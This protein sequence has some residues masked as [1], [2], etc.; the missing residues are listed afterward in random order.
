MAMDS[1]A[2]TLITIQINLAGGTLARHVHEHPS[3]RQ[4]LN[5]LLRFEVMYVN[6]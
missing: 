5:D 6:R 2:S 4:V 3:H 1:A